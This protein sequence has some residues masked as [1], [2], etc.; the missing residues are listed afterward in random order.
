MVRSQQ[1]SILVYYRLH[2][3]RE[4]KENLNGQPSRLNLPVDCCETRCKN[5]QVPHHSQS[6]H[7]ACDGPENFSSALPCPLPPPRASSVAASLVAVVKPSKPFSRHTTSHV[8][9]DASSPPYSSLPR[10][11]KPPKPLSTLSRLGQRSSKNPCPQPQA[12]TPPATCVI[13]VTP[14]ICFESSYAGVSFRLAGMV[15]V[16]FPVPTV[17]CGHQTSRPSF[18][19]VPSLLFSASS[20]EFSADRCPDNGSPRLT[21]SHGSPSFNPCCIF[22]VVY[23]SSCIASIVLM[24]T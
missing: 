18:E 12:L 19:C 16:P 3:T 9:V 24:S 7:Q 20:D 5:S 13:L 4:V 17:P 22:R 23:V 8:Q 21:S 1:Q 14:G 6:S 10:C 2:A 11:P 15:P